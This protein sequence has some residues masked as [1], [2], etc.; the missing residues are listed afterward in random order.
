[1]LN[2]NE[3]WPEPLEQELRRLHAL[4][5][6][7]GRI[8]ETLGVTRNSAIGKIGRLGLASNGRPIVVRKRTPGRPS[9]AMPGYHAP[10]PVRVGPLVPVCDPVT[11][12]KRAPNQ[13][14]WPID[15]IPGPAMLMCG[16]AVHSVA[17]GGEEHRLSYCEAHYRLSTRP[18]RVR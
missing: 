8:A 1:M 16:T 3:R 7:A 15:G 6:S 2:T 13:C 5:W 9:Y 4:S 17:I 11:L 18:I 10:R 14:A 12:L